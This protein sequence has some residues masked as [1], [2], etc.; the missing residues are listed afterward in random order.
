[1][2]GS[3]PLLLKSLTSKIHPPLSFN[4]KE[5][6]NLLRLLNSSF[7][8]QLDKEHAVG[9]VAASH[10]VNTHLHAV[11]SS[12]LFKEA[13]KHDNQRDRSDSANSV[14]LV[15]ELLTRPMEHFQEQVANGKATIEIAT[16]CLNV[17]G[18]NATIY[19]DSIPFDLET[20]ASNPIQPVLHWLWA[21]GLED[22]MG[23]VD[24][25]GFLHSILPPMIKHHQ[26][27]HVW[28]WL[29]KLQKVIRESDS[30]SLEL[31]QSRLESLLTYFVL[32]LVKLRGSINEAIETFVLVGRS[33]AGY[34]TSHA[35]SVMRRPARR[36][37]G[38]MMNDPSHQI[39]VA[40]YEEFV[41]IISQYKFHNSVNIHARLAL[42]HPTKPD[43]SLALKLIQNSTQPPWSQLSPKSKIYRLTFYVRTTQTLLSLHRE[44]EAHELVNF[45]QDNMVAAAPT[46]SKSRREK[47][48]KPEDYYEQF[49]LHALVT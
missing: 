29:H 30:K 42:C 47:D 1:M 16:R 39:D 13:S 20:R 17:Q 12:P 5:S 32:G 9:D 27:Q 41:S 8:Q 35:E 24:E 22:S 3:G 11:L 31:V 45:V 18:K 6:R 48:E 28:R 26:D 33:F 43:P 14:K 10:P 21:S 37:I 34:A 40:P 49:N 25:P 4:P 36:L 19:K 7:R 15:Q 2:K 38:L 23:F 44:A 46:I